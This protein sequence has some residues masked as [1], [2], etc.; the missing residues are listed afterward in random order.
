M[1]DGKSIVSGWNDGKIRAFLPQSGK[2]L[3][4]INDAHINGV[5]AIASNKDSN[6]IV[7]GGMNGE[8]RIWKLGKQSQTIEASLKEHRSRVWSIQ[9]NNLNDRAISA[10]SDGSCIIWDIKSFTRIACMFESTMFKDLIYYP[11]NSQILTCGSNKKITYW[12]SCDAEEIRMLDGSIE[13]EITS[14]SITKSGETFASVGED[15][16]LKIWDYETGKCNYIGVGHS[17]TINKVKISPNQEFIV[18]AGNDGSIFFWDM[19]FELRQ[20]KK[21]LNKP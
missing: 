2:L 5:T 14:L 19:P 18:T 11:D 6:R 20:A 8:V 17:S 13:G 4:T 3:Y 7:S 16:L 15:M 21:D 1:T 10:S 12:D 9:I